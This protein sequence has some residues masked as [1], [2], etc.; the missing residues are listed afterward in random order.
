ML[1]IL[2]LLV[3]EEWRMHSSMFGGRMFA[4]FPAVVAAFTFGFS[5]FI[6]LFETVIELPDIYLFI[7]YMGLLFGAS[8]GAFAL[9]G[10]E[11]M[12]RRFGQA[13][14]LAYSGRTLPVSG[15][16]MFANVIANDVVFYFALFIVPF[17]I[18]FSGAAAFTGAVPVFSPALVVSLALSFM[19]GLSASFFLSTVYVRSGRAFVA[20]AALCAVAA[21]AGG[22]ALDI[23]MVRAFPPQAFFSTGSLSSLGVTLLLIIVPSAL[24]LAFVKTEFTERVRHFRDRIGSLSARFSGISA[25]PHFVAKDMLDLQRSEGGI[26]KV[27]FSFVIPLVLIWAM[28]FIFSGV[29]PVGGGTVFLVFSILVGA[30]ASTV[31][32]WLTEFDDFSSYAFLPVR[33]S[34]VIRSKLSGCVLLNV[35]SVAIIAG[36]ALLGGQAVMLPMGLAAFVAVGSYTISVTVLL[37]GLRPNILIYSART[38]LAYTAAIAP[39]MVLCI[40]VSVLLPQALLLSPFLLVALSALII[41][42]ALRRWDARGDSA[43]QF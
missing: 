41:R 36:A 26:G 17:F 25:S 11:V 38:F 13:S 35:S 4:L 21:F 16:T 2:R 15:R 34:D 5:L 9:L 10:R 3:K 18:G 33:M 14:M 19:V 39:V 7:N 37:A 28:L 31:Y 43:T 30:L 20:A 1:G 8:V 29:F 40:M 32:N 22:L 12:N 24:S 6:P 42:R 27:F 23:D